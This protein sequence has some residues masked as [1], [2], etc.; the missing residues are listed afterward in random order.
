[1]SI[2]GKLGRFVTG[3]ITRAL[4]LGAM[5]ILLIGLILVLDATLSPDKPDR[6]E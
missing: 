4:K 3:L 5:G 2:F 1:M 6:P